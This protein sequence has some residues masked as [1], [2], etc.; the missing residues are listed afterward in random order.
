MQAFLGNTAS[1]AT[2]NPMDADK[3]IES[4]IITNKS[5]TIV[6]INIGA[7]VNDQV[8][9]IAPMNMMLNPNESFIDK[10]VVILKGYKIDVQVSNGNVD[11]YFSMP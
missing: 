1:S 7:K 10:K 2:S 4:Y 9:L 8:I 3:L 5:A 11:F 6:T